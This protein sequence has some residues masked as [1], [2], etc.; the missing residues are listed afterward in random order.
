MHYFILT[1]LFWLVW[2]VFSNGTIL[3]V[4]DKYDSVNARDQRISE[5]IY[6]RGV[7]KCQW[8]L[9]GNWLID[10]DD[11]DDDDDD[12]QI[13]VRVVPVKAS[14]RVTQHTWRWRSRVDWP[15]NSQQQMMQPPYPDIPAWCHRVMLAC[16]RS[17]LSCHLQ[18]VPG[19]IASL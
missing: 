4:S 10:D 14:S 18:N 5:I 6:S 17:P 1:F 13:P 8:N 16:L 11:D 19:P 15:M 3:S 2:V 9:L 7:S 12:V